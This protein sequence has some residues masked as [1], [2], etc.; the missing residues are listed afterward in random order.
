MVL[1]GD[2]TLDNVCYLS[3]PSY[4]LRPEHSIKELLKKALPGIEVLNYAAAG[5][6]ST[7]V[8]EGKVP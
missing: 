3:K 6:T 1:I 4:P 7:D 8:L 5:F 2:T